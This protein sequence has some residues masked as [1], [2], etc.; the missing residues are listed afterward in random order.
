MISSNYPAL[1]ICY[2]QIRISDPETRYYCNESESGGSGGSSDPETRY[3]C[4][5]SESGGSGGSWR[6]LK[7]PGVYASIMLDPQNRLQTKLAISFL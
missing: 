1:Y 4:N 6:V 5:E 7:H 2:K 3:V